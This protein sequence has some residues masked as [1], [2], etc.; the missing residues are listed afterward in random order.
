MKA[1][2]ISQFSSYPLVWMLHSKRLDKKLNALHERALRI[3]NG[4]NTSSFNELLEKD[5]SVSIHHK[6]LQDLTMEMY[7]ISNNMSPAIL[8][9]IFAPRA[10]PYNLRDPVSFKIRKVHLVYNST[11]TL[12]HLETKIWSLVQ[13]EMRR[14]VSLDFKSKNRPYLIVPA[15]YAKNIYLK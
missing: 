15:D 3:T 13:H 8:N 7:K 9:V 10:A 6:N 5:N 11:E 14:S 1:V 2:I 4:D 12:S